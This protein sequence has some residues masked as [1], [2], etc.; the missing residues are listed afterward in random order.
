M[1]CS[2]SSSACG[3]AVFFP[4]TDFIINVSGPVDPGTVNAG[5]LLVNNLPANSFFLIN[6]NTT[7]TFHF[8]SSPVAQP[9]IQTMHIP[10][11]AFDC[12]GPMLEFTCTF[13]YEVPRPTQTPRPRPTP[14]PRP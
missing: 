1:S 13:R 8:N 7:I 6:G 10:A 11:G 2:V 5:D 14:H 9:G 3:T 4:P 12:G